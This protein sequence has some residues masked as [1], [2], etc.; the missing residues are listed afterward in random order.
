M[1]AQEIIQ[2]IGTLPSE[3]RAKIANYLLY[4]D[5]SWIPD[6]FQAA[7]QDLASGRLVEMETA[8][9]ETPPSDLR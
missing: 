5:T 7:M 4:E 6:D 1:S 9:R 8:L 2:Q 3:E